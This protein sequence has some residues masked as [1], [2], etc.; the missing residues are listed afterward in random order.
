MTQWVEHLPSK[1]ALSS[2]PS[3]TKN[4]EQKK[5]KLWLGTLFKW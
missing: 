5:V 1:E 3:V 4:K 2:N